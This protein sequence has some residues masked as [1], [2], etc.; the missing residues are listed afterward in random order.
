MWIYPPIVS[1]M[2]WKFQ[3]PT[4]CTGCGHTV[5]YIQQQELANEV[6]SL[7]R[8]MRTAAAACQDIAGHCTCDAQ[9]V[10]YCQIF[11]KRTHIIPHTLSSSRKLQVTSPWSKNFLVLQESRNGLSGLTTKLGN[12]S[13]WNRS[14]DFNRTVQPP[15]DA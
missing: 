12:F 9:R 13:K 10:R 1:M 4:C 2:H 6:S 5:Q 15:I 11:I 3:V 8:E 14:R 7:N